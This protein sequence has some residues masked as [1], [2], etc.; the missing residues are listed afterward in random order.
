MNFAMLNSQQRHTDAEWDE[1]EKELNAHFEASWKT[2]LNQARQILA[3]LFGGEFRAGQR[4]LVL[5]VSKIA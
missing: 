3:K 1:L 4:R 5:V 2:L